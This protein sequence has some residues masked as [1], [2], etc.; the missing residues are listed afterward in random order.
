MTDQPQPPTI[1][2]QFR[3]IPPPPSRGRGMK[4]RLLLGGVGAGIAVVSCL[5][6][7]AIGSSSSTTKTVTVAGSPG[8]AQTVTVFATATV[9]APAPAKAA[10]PTKAAPKPKAVIPDGSQVVVGVDVPS[11]TYDAHSDS[12]SCYYEIDKHASSDIIDNGGFH[13]GHIVVKLKAGEDFQSDSCGDWT[14]E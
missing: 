9:Q 14:K 8:P 11:G 6:G 10:A 4:T 1:V 5:I 13:S 7:A 12:S 2:D 3:P